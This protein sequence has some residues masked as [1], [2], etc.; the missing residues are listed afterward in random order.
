MK[1]Q[2]LC[3]NSPIDIFGF[4][5]F[6]QFRRQSF[7]ESFANLRTLGCA[8]V[9]RKSQREVARKNLSPSRNSLGFVFLF[10]L[11]FAFCFCGDRDRTRLRMSFWGGV[12]GIWYSHTGAVLVFSSL[13]SHTHT[14]TAPNRTA[15]H[16]ERQR[17]SS[18][19]QEQARL[20]CVCVQCW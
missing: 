15:Q 19:Q 14:H 17:E 9:G 13:E 16:N 1:S 20:F 18:T 4:L 2:V 8:G 6:V 5:S 3:V 7:Q 12:V 10:F 11:G